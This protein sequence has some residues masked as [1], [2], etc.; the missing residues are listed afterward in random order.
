MEARNVASHSDNPSSPI[1]GQFIPPLFPH[2]LVAWKF[3]PLL[4]N[5]FA[6]LSDFVPTPGGKCLRRNS[7]HSIMH[8]LPLQQEAEASIMLFKSHLLHWL[9]IFAEI[10][11][12][13]LSHFFLHAD[14][15]TG[16]MLTFCTGWESRP[17]PRWAPWSACTAGW[18]PRGGARTWSTS[19][20]SPAQQYVLGLF[21][22]CFTIW[23]S[24]F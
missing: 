18:T 20:S 15:L 22:N 10:V 2:P 4:Q 5:L 16:I 13:Q 8:F 3:S 24:T 17:L 19:C 14:P 12:I 9:R 6:H 1:T 23:Q 11:K 21:W 7:Q